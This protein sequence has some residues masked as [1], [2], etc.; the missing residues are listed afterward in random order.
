[1]NYVCYQRAYQLHIT[2]MLGMYMYCIGTIIIFE[3]YD[4]PIVHPMKLTIKN[5]PIKGSCMPISQG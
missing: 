1:M 3:A 4:T 5:Y 2:E